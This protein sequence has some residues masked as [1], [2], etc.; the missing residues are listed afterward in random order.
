MSLP[1]PQRLMLLSA[2]SLLLA[3]SLLFFLADVRI[4]RILED[5]ADERLE[6]KLSAWVER[7]AGENAEAHARAFN[8]NDIEAHVWM[9]V[10][11]SNGALL[12]ETD[13]ENPP[14]AVLEERLLQRGATIDGRRLRGRVLADGGQLVMGLAWAPYAQ[15]LVAIRL[16]LAFVLLLMC[17]AGLAAAV[18]CFRRAL[19]SVGSVS[20]GIMEVVSNGDLES[21]V[22]TASG[23]RET[24]QLAEQFNAMLK[25]LR[26]QVHG[27]LQVMDDIAHDI[28]T[29]I[30]R[31]R[32]VAE[33]AL[34][35][36]QPSLLEL[37]LASN[38]IEECDRILSLVNNMLEITAAESSVIRLK[39]EPV[40]LAEMVKTAADLF[41]PMAADKNIDLDGEIINKAWVVGDEAYLQRILSNLIDN[42][43]KYTPEGGK[44][45]LHLYQEADRLVL[46]VEDN[47][48]GVP[49]QERELIFNRFYRG[50][51]SRTM[52]GNGL[53]LTFVRA[54]VEAMRGSISYV[55]K[56]EQGSIFRL[57]LPM[58]GGP[59]D[60]SSTKS[61]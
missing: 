41:E 43:V 37:E 19:Q 7:V 9:R 10:A 29:P 14:P 20:R 12:A 4:T 35:K 16:L 18:A 3:A 27:T 60:D 15:T 1:L 8:E 11:A 53:G 55:P 26:K 32:G 13:R 54:M 34:T 30:M 49:E 23:F 50:D 59:S 33:V 6:A 48:I 52:Q 24:D 25:R 40:D 57:S 51:K 22:S 21:E 58:T 36:S 42:A 39:H 56:L 46:D 38:S 17:G 31:I 61:S 28:R 47:G 44:V 5:H 45:F 2:A